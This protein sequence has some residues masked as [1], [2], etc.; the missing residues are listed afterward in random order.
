L[1]FN[2]ITPNGETNGTYYT[3]TTQSN[4]VNVDFYAD[5]TIVSPGDA[6]QFTDNSIVN[7][8][9]VQ[10]L[11]DFGDG[12]PLSVE[13]NPVHIYNN[14]GTYSVT[15]QV[16]LSYNINDQYST[17]KTNYITVLDPNNSGDLECYA[18]ANG[19][20]AFFNASYNGFNSSDY[21]YN[22]SFNF[23]DGNIEDSEINTSFTSTTHT[24]TDG[25]FQ[26][27]VHLRITNW[28]N[29]DVFEETVMCPELEIGYFNPCDYLW[30]D[31]YYKDVNDKVPAYT[32]AQPV[33][34]YSDV[35]GGTP[36]YIYCW[37]FSPD[38]STGYTNDSNLQISWDANPQLTF[39]HEGNY[40]VQLDVLDVT[41]GCVS[42][43]R[44]NVQ[45]ISPW[46]CYHNFTIYSGGSGW[47]NRDFAVIKSMEVDETTGL[48]HLCSDIFYYYYYIPWNPVCL[49]PTCVNPPIQWHLNNSHLTPP[50]SGSGFFNDA[51]Y[52]YILYYF[53]FYDKGIYDL[54]AN[55]NSSSG[56]C[57]DVEDHL[58]LIV[59]DCSGDANSQ[60]VLDILFY[61]YNSQP[62]ND[63]LVLKNI[64]PIPIVSGSFHLDG[65]ST[66]NSNTSF[67][68]FSFDFIA[69]NEVVL[70]NG[71]ETVGNGLY[72]FET[73]RVEY[74]NYY[75]PW[76]M[77]FEN[78]SNN[79]FNIKNEFVDVE[80]LF[81]IFPNPFSN[82]IT[83]SFTIH[84]DSPVTIS[85]F[86][87]ASIK[88]ITL[89]DEQYDAGE[90]SISF[91]LNYLQ[92]GVYYCSLRSP[93]FSKTI[94][95]VKL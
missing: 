20:N 85:V 80:N 91:N 8:G 34:L 43:V 49:S 37:F 52:G 86:N 67:F 22:F 19:Y 74:C 39:S 48:L 44:H 13:T 29:T 57:G 81:T 46:W 31:F 59:T 28:D 62:P 15:H 38:P 79:I 54:W 65:N 69:C 40:P 23:D 87:T 25:I 33:S 36:P 10:Y 2:K 56:A 21:T 75:D 30:V 93:F 51:G 66:F 53:N 60:D 5:H 42:S 26:P 17:T 58:P 11:W 18:Y 32:N 63:L 61:N 72:I 94:K 88:I 35:S 47:D 70:E 73:D 50:P 7:A 89:C 92:P 77:T 78:D 76:L 84:E 83:L 3:F 14:P 24:Y 45:V 71:F 68:N 27:S 41:T 12:T 95:I 55:V 1:D 82:T 4:Y 16:W 90:Y 64:T 6:V 9:I